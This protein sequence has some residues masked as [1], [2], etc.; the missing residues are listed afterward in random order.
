MFTGVIEEVGRVKRIQK[1][2]KHATIAIECDTVLKDIKQ[3]DSIS[4]NGIC[5][6]VT[7]FGLNTFDA[8]IMHD[9]WKDTHLNEINVGD[10]VNLER[11]LKV[12]DRLINS[13]TDVWHQSIGIKI[14][15]CR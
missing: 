3:G 13:S 9:T 10:V 7:R 11:A 8:D 2:F 14:K 1:G 5:L 15:D 6:T 4:T 12:G